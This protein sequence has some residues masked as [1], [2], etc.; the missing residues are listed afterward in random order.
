MSHVS[1]SGKAAIAAAVVAAI[2]AASA[3]QAQEAPAASEDLQTVT[4]TG[5]F[6]RRSEGFTPASPVAE[7]N[8]EDFESHA[9]KTV[10]D[11]LTELPYSFNTQ[12]AVGRAVGAS[13]GSGS[14]NLRNLG[15]GATLVLLNSRRTV[16]DAVT[17][18]SVDVNALVPQVMIERIEILK[19]GASSIY[20]SDAV[21]GVA[22]FLTRSNFDGF[23]V[24]GQ[25]DMREEGNNTD[26]RISGL[27]GS[28]GERG[29]VGGFVLERVAGALMTHVRMLAGP[30]P[31]Q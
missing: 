29:V 16:R 30:Q 26:W 6:I 28:Q 19:D 14:L 3:A 27:W 17:L 31:R 13:N 10:A 25:G 8:R 11:F 23:E 2:A 21:G 18:T 24:V 1:T 15:A 9:P 20:G 12:F 5:S 7:V 22:N 4:I